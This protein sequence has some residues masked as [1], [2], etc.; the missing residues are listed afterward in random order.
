MKFGKKMAGHAGAVVKRVLFMGFSVQVILGLAWMCRNLGKVQDFG[1]PEAVLYRQFYLLLGKNVVLVQLLQLAAG[2]FTGYRFLRYLGPAEETEDRTGKLWRVW[3]SLVLL[4]FPFAMQCHLA[5]LPFSFMGSLF[6]WMLVFLMEI[7]VPSRKGSR[8]GPKWKRPWVRGICGLLCGG[9]IL[10]LSG[11]VDARKRAEPGY[12]LAGSMASRFAWPTMW[13]D[14]GAW[15]EELREITGEY[16]WEASYCPG[17]FRLVQA[18]VEE[19][20]GKKEAQSRYWQMARIGWKYH[21]QMIIRQIGWDGMGYLVTPL[22]V[23]V[24]LEGEGYDSYTGRNYEIMRDHAPVLT[25]YYVDYGC[26]WFGWSL[27]LSLLPAAAGKLPAKGAGRKRALAEAGVCV[28]VSCL[29]ALI[30]TMRGAGLLD[31]KYTIAINQLWLVWALL[32]MGE[33]TSGPPDCSGRRKAEG[34]G[35]SAGKGKEDHGNATVDPGITAAA[36][37]GSDWRPVCDRG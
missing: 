9:M 21:K 22:I 27:L 4:T 10:V 25:R 20:L 26:W 30:L 6:L 18:A 34:S 24:L 1:E 17:N 11:D 8:P 36:G 15:D 28:L 33:K 14:Q 16:M 32:L 13:H 35:R 2:F 19:S 7:T 37:A 31:Y 23:P 12:G 5:I 3:Q 29:Y